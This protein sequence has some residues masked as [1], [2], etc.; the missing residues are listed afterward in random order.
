MKAMFSSNFIEI[1]IRKL[2]QNLFFSG[3]KS[4]VYI[5][6]PNKFVKNYLM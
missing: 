2:K 3:L 4:E 5:F 1:L 6:V